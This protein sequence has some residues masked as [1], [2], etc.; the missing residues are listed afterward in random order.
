M[1]RAGPLLALLGRGCSLEPPYVG[2]DPAIPTSWPVGDPYLAQA[3]AGLPILTY[4]Q[5]FQ[6]ARLQALIIEALT[7]NRDLMT[8]V[9]NIAAAR[10]QYHIQRAQLLPTINAATGASVSGDRSGG[11]D[12]NLSA[13]LSVPSFELDL[14]GRVRSLTHA[15]LARYLATE[16]GA[17]ATR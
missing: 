12:A 14:F 9:S 7:N 6:D 17:R 15:Q 4:T 8:S 13:G 16:A 2:P 11:V 5:I 1:N 3:E 10:E